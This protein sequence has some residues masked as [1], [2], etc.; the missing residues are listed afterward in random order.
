MRRKLHMTCDVSSFLEDHGK[1]KM[2]FFFNSSQLLIKRNC[3]TRTN[4]SR[5][6]YVL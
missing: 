5:K 6:R 1:A 2:K 3:T 4:L